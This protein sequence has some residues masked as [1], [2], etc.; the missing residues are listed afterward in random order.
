[1]RISPNGL[2]QVLTYLGRDVITDYQDDEH[3][4]LDPEDNTP[5]NKRIRRRSWQLAIWGCAV[6][7]QCAVMLK[8][9]RMGGASGPCWNCAWWSRHYRRARHRHYAA[10]FA[11]GRGGVF[12]WY[13]P[14]YISQAYKVEA[15]IPVKRSSYSYL[16]TRFPPTKNIQRK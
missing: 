5:T 8:R 14:I 16:E 6:V 4:R 2:T 12:L 11:A 15:S 3:G 10:A 13:D 1:M 9:Y 7:A